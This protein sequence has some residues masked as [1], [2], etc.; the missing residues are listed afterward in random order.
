MPHPI[1]R[2]ATPERTTRAHKTQ[3]IESDLRQFMMPFPVPERRMPDEFRQFPGQRGWGPV[4]RREAPDGR[5][6]AIPFE[7]N[8]TITRRHIGGEPPS[9]SRDH[10]GPL[11]EGAW[12]RHGGHC[13]VR[14]DQ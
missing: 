2:G 13:R 6:L 7:I 8:R 4:C 3:T 9:R 14:A 12:C 1:V 11:V 10:W 5:K